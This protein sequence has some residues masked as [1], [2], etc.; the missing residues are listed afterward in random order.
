MFVHSE[1][2]TLGLKFEM[3][4]KFEEPLPAIALGAIENEGTLTPR[5]APLPAGL[6]LLKPGGTVLAVGSLFPTQAEPLVSAGSK[7]V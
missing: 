1:L 4:E 2:F 6:V 5:G 7:A 3:G